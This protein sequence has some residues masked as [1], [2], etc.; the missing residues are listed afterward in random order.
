M[1]RLLP[2]F[3]C[4]LTAFSS[5]AKEL[6]LKTS[7]KEVTVFQSGA[8]VIRAGSVMIPAGESDIV[9]KD[10]TSLLKKESIQ[11]NGLGNFTILSVNHQQNLDNLI[12]D[13]NKCLELEKKEKALLRQLE[14]LSINIE[15]MRT[16]E[17]VV[18][19]LQSVSTATE[20]ITVEQVTK[21]QELLRTKLTLIK[22]EKLVAGRRMKELNDEHQT[23]LQELNVLK[24]P[25]QEV[26][27]E[28]VIK[29]LCK[30]ETK[31]EF[32]VH[33][34]VPNAHWFP[35]YDLRVKSIA[36]PMVIDYKA[37][38]SQQSGED[39]NT[40][41][42]KLSTGDPS[43]SSQRP[44]LDIWTLS[45]N[46]RYVQ[47]AQQGNYFKYS[48][49]RFGKAKGTVLDAKTG[50]P[51]PYCTIA[52][53]GT[54]VGTSTD[55][56][57]NFSLVLPANASPI[58]IY[59]IGYQPQTLA[60]K[61]GT[62]KIY[63]HPS[64]TELRSVEIV[65]TNSNEE[66]EVD[67]GSDAIRGNRKEG[68]LDTTDGL[69]YD[70]GVKKSLNTVSTEFVLDDKYTILSDPKNITVKIQSI[71][72]AVQYQ[73][74]CAPRLDKDV[75]LTALMTDWEKYNLLQGQANIFF[76]GTLVGTTLLETE[77][78]S[79]TLSISLGRDQ[80]VKV[81]RKRAL[82]YSK[83]QFL[84][85]SRI[86]YRQWDLT[87][88]NGKGQDINIILEDQYPVSTDD[89]IEVKHEEQSAAKLDEKTGI[90]T[91]NYILKPGEAK[92]SRLTYSTQFPKGSFVSLD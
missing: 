52:V 39:W 51:L 53:E 76:E 17:A 22:N 29:V 82:A 2:V 6:E 65:A 26:T 86:A 60:V 72:S 40:V 90:V 5:R 3:L 23:L 63:M 75:F 19:N 87:V 43:R 18:M 70:P 1:K 30:K 27:Y 59:Y 88:K 33:Y 28:I 83:K 45:L 71:Q 54:Q 16:E 13:K 58:K 4:L 85:S 57:G 89:K 7:I 80:G 66:Y 69:S 64:V 61:A 9:I 34:I 55:I 35:T 8:Q 20:G 47:P 92:A 36:E 42:L 50:E 84:G 31:G 44:L 37:N 74:Y 14:E 15:V 46:Q 67:K 78:L 10:A 25:R 62:M 79:D 73:Y 32:D 41:K 91:W 21:A 81:E 68:R 12:Q 38:V 11:V 49:I 77:Y 56:D 24:T 48:D